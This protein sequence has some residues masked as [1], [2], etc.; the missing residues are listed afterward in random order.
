VPAHHNGEGR[1][2]AA[3][4]SLDLLVGRVGELLAQRFERAL[5]AAGLTLDQWR[6]LDMLADGKGHPMAGIAA[7]VM[8]PAPTLTKI[9]DRLVTAALVYRRPDEID[10]RRV[11]VFLSRRGRQVHTRLAPQIA[12]AENTFVEDLGVADIAELRRLM[13]RLAG[14]APTADLTAQ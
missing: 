10:R 14:V 12:A 8:A 2:P 3:T 6:V 7:H 9:I 5:G 11:L 4:V 1:P 13:E